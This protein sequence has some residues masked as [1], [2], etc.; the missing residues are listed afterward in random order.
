MYYTMGELQSGS[1]YGP[2][3]VRKG[4][5]HFGQLPL[6][7]GK[8]QMSLDYYAMLEKAKNPPKPPIQANATQASA[9]QG[10]RKARG[11]ARRTSLSDLRIQ[12]PQVNTQIALGAGGTS[13]NLG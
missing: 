7:P 11:S 3:Y 13:L 9:G 6:D 1:Y 10:T 2:T 8:R 12:R 4:V 5:Q